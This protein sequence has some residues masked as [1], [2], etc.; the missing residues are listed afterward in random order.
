MQTLS[1]VHGTSG[2]RVAGASCAALCRA[3]T[4]KGRLGLCR[5]VSP[6]PPVSSRFLLVCVRALMPFGC[7]SCVMSLKSFHVAKR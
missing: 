2:D 3:L 4:W 6:R 1:T 7:R 5:S